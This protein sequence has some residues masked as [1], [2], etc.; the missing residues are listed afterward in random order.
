M[1]DVRCQSIRLLASDW[2]P[3]SDIRKISMIKAKHDRLL[4]ALI[5]KLPIEI[6]RWPRADR[7]AWLQMVAMAFDVVYGP[8]G[9][10]RVVPDESRAGG[11]DQTPNT[12]GNVSADNVSAAQPVTAEAAP[13]KPQRFYVDR[14]GF[15]MGDGRPVAIGDLPAGAILWDERVGVERGDGA[16]ILWRDIGTSRRSLP[17]GVTLRPMFDAS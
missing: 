12:S 9:G 2:H 14:D 1:S 15:A 17:L 5:A 16:A 10:I 4:V 7:I 11:A 13:D 3:A 8:S 6:A